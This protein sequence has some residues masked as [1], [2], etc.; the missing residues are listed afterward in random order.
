MIRVVLDT[1]VY[2]SGVIARGGP[3]D[4]ILRAWSQRV[5]SSPGRHGSVARVIDAG[6]IERAARVLADAAASPAQVIV[7]GSA[8]RGET[9]P[10]SDLDF[11]VLEDDV[12]DR[13]APP[14]R[15]QGRAA[16]RVTARKGVASDSVLPADALACTPVYAV[17]E[18]QIEPA[19]QSSASACRQPR[20]IRRDAAHVA[21]VA[22]R[23]GPLLGSG[24][25]S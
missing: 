13:V 21:S 8:A 17:N 3:P 20:S 7:F 12:P 19:F 11:L 25:R 4:L 14:H 5:S 1:G 16:R 18:Q 15:R 24:G 23:P 22:Q 6:V 9:G 2:V 10:D